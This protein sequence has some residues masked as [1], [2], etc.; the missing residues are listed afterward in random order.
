MILKCCNCKKESEKSKNIVRSI[1]CLHDYCK[2]CM[3]DL[4]MN[5]NGFCNICS[6]IKITY[7]DI[8][9]FLAKNEL[10]DNNQSY[11]KRISV[12]DDYF[13]DNT[14]WCFKGKNSNSNFTLSFQDF[15]KV[16]N[17]FY[18]IYEVFNFLIDEYKVS[19]F[20]VYYPECKMAFVYKR[21]KS[22]TGLYYFG[23]FKF[24]NILF[25]ITKERMDKEFLESKHFINSKVSSCKKS[26]IMNPAGYS[27]C[28]YPKILK[29]YITNNSYHKFQN[30]KLI[31]F[32]DMEKLEKYYLSLMIILSKKQSVNDTSKIILSYVPFIEN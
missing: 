27:I 8:I 6:S 24:Y 19:N 32:I 10:F 5:K 25:N 9:P 28:P 15:S 7:K 22:Y 2:D 3:I 13:K 14:L 16:M 12:L 4:F 31:H 30:Y 20:V 11:S 1:T 26:N 29:Q 23:G 21:I 17:S 18:I